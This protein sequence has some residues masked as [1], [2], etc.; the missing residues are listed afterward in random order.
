MEQQNT[1]EPDGP[2]V[3]DFSSHLSGPIASYLLREFGVDTATIEQ[4][5]NEGVIA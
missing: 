5:K 2:R 1:G 3:V 4:L